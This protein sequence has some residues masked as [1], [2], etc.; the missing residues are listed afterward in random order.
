M[1]HVHGN[2]D[3]ILIFLAKVKKLSRNIVFFGFRA[4][5]VNVLCILTQSKTQ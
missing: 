1:L 4:K 2:V 5:K 3:G